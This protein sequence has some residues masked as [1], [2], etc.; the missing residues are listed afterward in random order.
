M[1]GLR[2]IGAAVA[3]EVEACVKGLN[4]KSKVEFPL[5]TLKEC[6]CFLSRE[7]A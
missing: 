5:A 7:K 6:Q 4:W 3:E 2:R 1:A